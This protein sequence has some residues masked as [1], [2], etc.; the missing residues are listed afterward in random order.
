[1]DIVMSTTLLRSHEDVLEARARIFRALGDE[2][3]LRIFQTIVEAEEPLNVNEICERVELSANLVSHHLQCLKDCTLVSMT[4]S[5][6]KRFY[7]VSR[8]EAVKMVRLADE[9]ITQDIENVLG[10]EI[11]EKTSEPDA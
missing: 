6:R 9:C 8:S 3:R 5:G 1:M 2:N 11:V 4:K 10:C 7:E